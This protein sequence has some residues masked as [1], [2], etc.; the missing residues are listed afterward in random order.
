MSDR[1][2][3]SAEDDGEGMRLEEVAAFVQKA[4]RLDAPGDARVQV[5]NGFRQQIKK[6]EVDLS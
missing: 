2:V 6:L 5:T 3:H 4:M 1:L